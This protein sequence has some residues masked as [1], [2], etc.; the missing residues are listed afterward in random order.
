MPPSRLDLQLDRWRQDLVNLTRRNRLLYFGHLRTATLEV[1][2]PGPAELAAGLS[3]ASLRRWSLGLPAGTDLA[4]F[5]TAPVVR[6]DWRIVVDKPDEPALLRSLK[7]LERKTEQ[8]YLDKGLWILY[9]TLGML[10]WVDD[11]GK[12]AQSPL[13]LVPVRVR[14]PTP[15]DDYYLERTDDDVVANPALALKLAEYGIEL[16]PFDP[17]GDID[18]SSMIVDVGRRVA[19]RAGWK[20]T[21]RSVIATFTFHKE[22][23]YRDLLDNG[24]RLADHPLVRALAGEQDPD[25]EL[26]VEPV[27]EDE[28]D[29]RVP[30]EQLVNIL[31]SD[32][33]QRQCI[34]AAR[35]GATFAMDGPPGTGKSQTIA[36]II[37]E[38][39]HAGR[40]VLFVS[41]KAAALEVVEER[42][43]K[44]G[45]GAFLLELHS[46]K[47]TRKEVAKTLGHALHHQPATPRGPRGG[48]PATR[49]AAP[50]AA[51]RLCARRERGAPAARALAARRDRASGAP[52]RCW[53]CPWAERVEPGCVAVGRAACRVP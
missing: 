16:S 36:N 2:A 43:N 9:L 50:A 41:E 5:G 29:T 7:A 45:L 40:T 12:P 8:E 37:A 38:V 46:H 32:A 44:A 23:M 51:Q 30:P 35:D 42:L 39:L 19:G 20:V 47:A 1:L 53:H 33:S 3:D 34:A 6:P 26:G 25:V 4:A 22:A 17:A 18:P 28:L 48:R 24:D 15:R 13:L 49:D 21:G 14:R 10:E 11:D 27:P 52:G 31:P